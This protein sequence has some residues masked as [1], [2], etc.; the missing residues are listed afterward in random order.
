MLDEIGVQPAA[1]PVERIGVGRQIVHART[2]AR[3]R[4][5][6]AHMLQQHLQVVQVAEPFLLALQHSHERR[7]RG[8]A[9]VARDFERVAQLLGRDAHGVKALGHV[10]RSGLV[11]RDAPASFARRISR[12]ASTPRHCASFSRLPSAFALLPSALCPLPCL[13]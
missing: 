13:A 9:G 7:R 12:V 5:R 8:H 2:D 6:F 1:L 4:F 3:R 11:E 10:Q